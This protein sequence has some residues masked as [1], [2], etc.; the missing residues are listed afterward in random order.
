VWLYDWDA[1]CET[2]RKDGWDTSPYGK[3][4]NHI[5]RAVQADFDYCQGWLNDDWHWMGVVVYEINEYDGQC[6]PSDSLWGIE[7]DATQYIGEIT[8][9]MIATLTAHTVPE[10]VPAEPETT[11]VPDYIPAK[12][13]DVWLAQRRGEEIEVKNSC[14]AWHSIPFP[15]WHE[16]YEYRVK[17]DPKPEK[18]L[19]TTQEVPAARMTSDQ[20]N[21]LAQKHF[22]AQYGHALG[23]AVNDWIINAILDAANCNQDKE[24]P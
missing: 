12:H 1:A 14:N 23:V 7:S 10:P 4:A 6:G 22:K 5:E 16:D 20:A 3:L 17:P 13:H 18:I 11:K 2:A 8:R 9:Y 19:S 24:Q 15:S 21:T